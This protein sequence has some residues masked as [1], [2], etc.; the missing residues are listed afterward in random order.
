M[1]TKKYVPYTVNFSPKNGTLS[2]LLEIQERQRNYDETK[3]QVPQT[4]GSFSVQVTS[5]VTESIRL[6]VHFGA[7]SL[8][9][10]GAWTTVIADIPASNPD[11]R[12]VSTKVIDLPV[13]P[14][15]VSMHLRVGGSTTHEYGPEEYAA[16]RV[17]PLPGV[18]NIN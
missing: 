10:G 11:R 9:S 4:N 13:P 5:T 6:Q 1:D 12:I 2:G 15:G 18:E 7:G 17:F 3:F 14:P 16:V 8:T